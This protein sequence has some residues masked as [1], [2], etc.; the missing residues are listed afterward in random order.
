[1]N[2][3][4]EVASRA[5][6]DHQIGFLGIPELSEAVLSRTQ[7]VRIEKMDDVLAA[8]SKPSNSKDEVIRLAARA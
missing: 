8:D 5:F 2:A 1:L 6:L 3:A 4:D 7:R